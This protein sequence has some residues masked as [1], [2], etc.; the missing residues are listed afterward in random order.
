MYLNINEA[1]YILSKFVNVSTI[2]TKTNIS[3]KFG[4]DILKKNFYFKLL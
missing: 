2:N 3:F 4:N 1:G